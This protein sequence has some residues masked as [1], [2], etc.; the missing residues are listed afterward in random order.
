MVD[1]HFDVFLD[2]IFENFIEYHSNCGFI[3]QIE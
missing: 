1:D 2:S 3:E